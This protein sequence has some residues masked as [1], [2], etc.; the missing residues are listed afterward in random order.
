MFAYPSLLAIV[1]RPP[2]RPRRQPTRQSRRHH[3]SGAVGRLS[4]KI[5]QCVGGQQ[6][7]L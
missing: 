5:L 6:Q 7:F 3:R 1:K 2:A 4:E